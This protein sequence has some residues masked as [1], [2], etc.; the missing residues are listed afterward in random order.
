[1]RCDTRRWW[2]WY[3]H[4][5]A[6][7]KGEKVEGRSQ[8]PHGRRLTGVASTGRISILAQPDRR[9]SL[10]SRPQQGKTH[11]AG[12]LLAACSRKQD[13]ALVHARKIPDRISP[14]DFPVE[15]KWE[16]RLKNSRLSNNEEEEDD[17]LVGIIM[18]LRYRWGN[19]IRLIREDNSEEGIVKF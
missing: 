8:T 4:I 17:P 11:R 13:C 3:R 5:Q 12:V 7:R 19:G 10:P 15:E 2:W 14:L 18:I 6:S 9:L 16:R 1:M